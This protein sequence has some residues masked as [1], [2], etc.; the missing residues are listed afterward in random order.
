M[1]IAKEHVGGNALNEISVEDMDK[2]KE[3]M[4]RVI[5]YVIIA[6]PEYIPIR[7]KEWRVYRDL[8]LRQVEVETGISNAYLSQ[9]ETGKI[10]SPSFSV[11][12]KLCNIYKVRLVID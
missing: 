7:L 1:L 2:L 5:D 12:C 4:E 9:L 11:V 6:K 3:Y 8:T 10:K